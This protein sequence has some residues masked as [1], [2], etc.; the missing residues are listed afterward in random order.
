MNVPRCSLGPVHFK[1]LYDANADPWQFCASAYEQAKYR[2][3]IGTLGTGPSAPRL[4]LD[5][6]SGAMTRMLAPRCA[7]LLAVHIVEQPLTA[8]RGLC[9][10]QPWVRFQRMQVPG[11]WPD[12]TF[13]VIVLSE[14]PLAEIRKRRIFCPLTET[15]GG[16]DVK[17]VAEQSEDAVGGEDGD[18]E[19]QMAERLEMAADPQ[20]AATELIL[21]AGIGTFGRS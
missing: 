17:S 2:G 21:D 12:D 19:H 14:E 5:V 4:R 10:D 15:S 11:E 18:T 9:V 3:T 1:R 13:D 8:A 20:V 7:A 6:R 16:V